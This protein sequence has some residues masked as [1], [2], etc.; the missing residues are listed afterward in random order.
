MALYSFK[1]SVN[2]SDDILMQ[3]ILPYFVTSAIIQLYHRLTKKL[4]HCTPSPP[5][6]PQHTQYLH[7][8]MDL[9]LTSDLTLSQLPSVS[10]VYAELISAVF[11]LFIFFLNFI[12][13]LNFT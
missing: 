9:Q 4:R 7:S 5:A 13:F 11:I 3:I 12:L 10:L 2:Q 1:L 6:P 8:L